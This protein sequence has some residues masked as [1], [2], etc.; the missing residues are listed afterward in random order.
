MKHHNSPTANAQDVMANDWIDWNGGEC[1]VAHNARV[2]VQYENE[3]REVA[4]TY[5]PIH[6]S[7]VPWKRVRSGKLSRVTAYRVV[8]S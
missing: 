1:P 2:I 6:A 4:E 5:T 8:Q 3:T 7:Y